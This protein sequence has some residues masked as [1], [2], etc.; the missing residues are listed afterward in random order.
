[1]SHECGGTSLAGG[2]NHRF[3][4]DNPEG[5]H[6]EI[7][8]ALR[9]L[10][11]DFFRLPVAY[12]TGKGCVVPLGL[13]IAQPMVVYS[14]RRNGRSALKVRLTVQNNHALRA[15]HQKVWARES[16]SS[17]TLWVVMRRLRLY[18]SRPQ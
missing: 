6:N 4:S 18:E 10:D 15:Q 5:R 11:C 8:S 17:L 3:G 16:Q 7:V 2:V 13:Q 12:T 9:A 1:M 14:E